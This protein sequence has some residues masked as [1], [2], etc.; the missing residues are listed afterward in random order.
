MAKQKKQPTTV[1]ELLEEIKEAVGDRECIFRGEPS[2]QFGEVT[3]SLYRKLD[4]P[5]VVP[6]ELMATDQHE[7]FAEELK[8]L[9]AK[10]ASTEAD[11]AAPLTKGEVQADIKKLQAVVADGRAFPDGYKKL[12]LQL[13]QRDYASGAKRRASLIKSNSEILAELQHYGG[14]TNLIDFSESYLVALFFACKDD[15]YSENNGHLIVLPKRGIKEISGDEETPKDERFI[16]RPLPDNRRALIQRS[17]MLHE[18]KGHLEYTDEQIILVPIPSNLKNAILDYLDKF[19]DISVDTL[20]PDIQGYIESQKFTR[21]SRLRMRQAYT[22]LDEGKIEGALSNYSRA[23]DM[24]NKNAV[25]YQFRARVYEALGRHEEALVDCNRAIELQTQDGDFRA[26]LYDARARILTGLGHFEEALSDCNRGLELDIQ[27]PTFRVLLYQARALVYLEQKD[28]KR[29]LED[30]ELGLG[31]DGLK[32]NVYYVL[33]KTRA[34]VYR[35]LGRYE[36]ALEDCDRSLEFAGVDLIRRIWVYRFRASIYALRENLN[37]EE[38]QQD[39]DKVE[40]NLKEAL[41]LAKKLGRIQNIEEI[42]QEL[43]ILNKLN[44]PNQK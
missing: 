15:S 20:F 40:V 19:C 2:D 14:E 18:P 26:T 13:L 22:Q 5:D 35:S 37:I 6:T 12:V 28:Y 3:S 8:K 43:D 23:I 41:K 10:Y 38:T 25:S 17:V 27:Y 42:Q 4:E 33:H 21:L 9:S 1:I 7:Q 44:T 34:M 32:D 29:A 39:L 11:D 16:I 36:K 31:L 24:D 30:C